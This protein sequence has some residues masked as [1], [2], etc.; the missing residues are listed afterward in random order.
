MK[1]AKDKGLDIFEG[2]D[3][4]SFHAYGNLTGYNALDIFTGT[5]DY[6]VFGLPRLNGGLFPRAITVVGESTTGKTT[7]AVRLGSSIID[8]WNRIHGDLAEMIFFDVED[9]TSIKR[10]QMLTNWTDWEILNRIKH[11]TAV[12][13]VVDIYNEIRQLADLKEKNKDKLMV[14]TGQ[15]DL[16]GSEIKVYSP[17]IALV[18]SIAVL[19]SVGIDEMEFDKTGDLKVVEK[20]AGNMVAAQ[21]AKANTAFIK[22]VKGYLSKYNIILIMVNHITEEISTSMYD[23]PARYLTFLKPGQKLKGGKELVYQ[24]FAII[25]LSVKTRINDKDPIYGD[26]IRG[27]VTHLTLIKNKSNVEGIPIPMV[28][29]QKTGYRPELSDWEYLY[30]AAYGFGGSPAR[31]YLHIL[32]EVTFTKKGLYEACQTNPLLARAMSFTAR[33]K[34]ICDVVK[35]KTAPNLEELGKTMAYNE[36]VSAIVTFT[37]AYPGYES[38]DMVLPRAIQET[39]LNAQKYLI[40]NDLKFDMTG[41]QVFDDEWF[42]ELDAAATIAAGD[43]V[44]VPSFNPVTPYDTVVKE[45]DFEY[46]FPSEEE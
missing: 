7:L 15:R 17:T 16:D 20:M 8:R 39:A 3:D 43:T 11:S 25:N 29:D 18:D 14:K 35:N 4:D 21:E 31:Y 45:E 9:N 23:I 46:I 37:E 12:V 26:V 22:K 34:M 44:C 1:Y 36:R 6:D 42:S 33:L 13:S 41:A 19:N 28:F 30:N 2:D 32:P 5:V 40:S 24:S 27:S 38:L 10:I